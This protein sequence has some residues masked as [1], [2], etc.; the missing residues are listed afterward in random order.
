MGIE[1]DPNNT[2]VARMKS[3]NELK[4]MSEDS[5]IEAQIEKTRCDRAEVGLAFCAE[6]DFVNIPPSWEGMIAGKEV[7]LIPPKDYNNVSGWTI[8]DGGKSTG[9]RA[10]ARWFDWSTKRKTGDSRPPEYGVA[11]DNWYERWSSENGH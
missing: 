7:E 6:C 4:A 8:V 2:V 5:L 11:G 9:R 3:W 1:V 10:C